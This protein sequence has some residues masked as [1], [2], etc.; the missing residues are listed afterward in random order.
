MGVSFINSPRT[1]Y[2]TFC[3]KKRPCVV[4]DSG[5]QPIVM[6]SPNLA[7]WLAAL[8]PAAKLLIVDD[9]RASFIDTVELLQRDDLLRASSLL[10]AS[11]TTSRDVKI[12][13][14]SV[15]E[16][17]VQID[18]GVT[19]GNGVVVRRGTWV[20]RGAIIGD[21]CVIGAPGINLYIGQDG[22]RRSLPHVAG[23]IIGENTSFGAGC[24]VARGILTSTT[25]GNSCIV[26]SLCNIGHGT[27]LG[28]NIWMSTGTCVAGLT[29]I[30][31]GATIAM[32]CTIRD[33]ICI[34]AHSNIGMGSVV[35]KSVRA[36]SSVF[37]N[38]ARIVGPIKAGPSR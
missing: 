10:P 25:I 8:W 4:S 34:G 23:V 19:V 32:G 35:T 9:P 16:P 28:D 22:R 20:K 7:H 33:D 30:E 21:N 6:V 38:P 17:G 27:E 26:G 15:I 14:G 24:V 29:R 31:T 18:P 3:D 2:L 11:P 37:G 1:G 13:S 36:G 12:G 5:I